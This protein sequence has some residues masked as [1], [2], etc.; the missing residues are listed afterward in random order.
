MLVFENEWGIIDDLVFYR[1]SRGDC[2]RSVIY[3]SVVKTSYINPMPYDCEIASIIRAMQEGELL[4][5][6]GR[7][8]LAGEKF[9]EA[10]KLSVKL[11]EAEWLSRLLYLYVQNVLERGDKNIIFKETECVELLEYSYALACTYDDRKRIKAIRDLCN[12]YNLRDV[13]L[14]Y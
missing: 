2:D 4:R 7:F 10:I 12:K 9:M 13:S 8:K 5:E 1:E 3:G 11:Y 6:I 14:D